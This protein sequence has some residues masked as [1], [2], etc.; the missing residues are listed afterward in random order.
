MDSLP[1]AYADTVQAVVASVSDVYEGEWGARQWQRIVV[2]HESL[3]HTAQPQTSTIAFAI[4]Q[5]PQGQPEQ[6]DFR[7]SD[8]AE[9]GFKRIA[10]IVHAQKGQHWTV[11]SLTI[12][13]DGHYKFDFSYDK[14]YR[15]SGHLQDTRFDDYLKRYLA[16]QR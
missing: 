1:Q 14:P 7:L 2:D 9:Q 13:S 15:L 5:A 12:E 16:E 10:D 6:V 4:A 8:A 3:L 11:C